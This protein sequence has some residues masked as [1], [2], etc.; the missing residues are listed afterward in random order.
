MRGDPSA[1]AELGGGLN[2]RLVHPEGHEDVLR[3]TTDCIGDYAVATGATVAK[4]SHLRCVSMTGCQCRWMRANLR[5]HL[6][7]SILVCAVGCGGQARS[8]AESGDQESAHGV[9]AVPSVAA[10]VPSAT[11]G[12]MTNVAARSSIGGIDA[13]LDTIQSADGG[14]DASLDATASDRDFTTSGDGRVPQDHRA[15]AGQCLE[16][17]EAGLSCPDGGVPA[18]GAPACAQNSDCTMGKNGRCF[19]Y[20]TAT[21]AWQTVCSYDECLTDSDCPARVPCSCRFPS[22]SGN[23]N[24]C[25]KQSNCATDSDCSPGGYCSPSNILSPMRG[26]AYGFFCHTAGDHC[27]DDSDCRTEG[28]VA[29]CEFDGT[30]GY[31]FCYRPPQPGLPSPL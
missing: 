6:S 25:L 17:R 18:P 24:V 27:L 29:S 4:A 7:M 22:I 15:S 1:G 20:P 31:W 28:G 30:Q 10:G 14:V 21:F 13:S 26:P 8:G 5:V 2:K 23:P 3:V 12:G 16:P 11:A 19:C 9:A